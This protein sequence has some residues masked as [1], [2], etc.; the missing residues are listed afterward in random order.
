MENNIDNIIARHPVGME[1]NAAGTY[2]VSFNEGDPLE[3]VPLDA[4][5]RMKLYHVV[6]RNANTSPDLPDLDDA[7]EKIVEEEDFDEEEYLSMLLTLDG[8]SF[9]DVQP[10]DPDIKFYWVADFELGRKKKEGYELA[11]EED[12][13]D[14]GV[15]SGSTKVGDSYSAEGVITYN[16]HTLMKISKR[17]AVL[18]D[19]AAAMK[20][21]MNVKG[22]LSKYTDKG[23][24]NKGTKVENID[25]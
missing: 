14:M 20:S 13:E 12:I 8:Y 1:K 16:E 15:L 5:S 7:P 4:S 2:T 25:T 6:K 23:I 21:R 24:E 10:A 9:R 3:G 11:E 22:T 17:K 18:I 19:K